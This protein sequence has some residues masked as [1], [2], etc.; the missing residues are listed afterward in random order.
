MMRVYILFF[1]LLPLCTLAQRNN[2]MFTATPN[3]FYPGD[4][5]GA[6]DMRERKVEGSTYWRKAWLPGTVLLV[7]GATVKDALLKYDLVSERLDVKVGTEIRVIPGNQIKEFVLIGADGPHRF[8]RAE[9]ALGLTGTYAG[10]FEWLYAGTYDL[11]TKERIE[12]LPPNYVPALDAGSYHDKIVADTRY[13][14]S[15]G[16]RLIELPK[17]KRKLRKRL[18]R[19][20]PGM[21]AYIKANN[22][23]PKHLDDLL[24]I[25]AELNRREGGE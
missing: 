15:D 1:I 5:V 23:N 18:E 24:Q 14:L 12:V 25:V 21:R 9:T 13:Y 11:M 8:V 22:L 10:F 3:E 2:P 19:L 4:E 20:S 7:S 16:D 6:F 17:G